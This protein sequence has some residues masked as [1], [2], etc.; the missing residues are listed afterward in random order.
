MSNWSPRHR[1]PGN[2]RSLSE[3]SGGVWLVLDLNPKKRGSQEQQLLALADA[4]A[5]RALPLAYLFSRLPPP[6]LGRELDAR[7]VTVRALDFRRP[8]AAAA[9][10]WPALVEGR[11]RLVHFHFVAPKSPLVMMARAAGA[12]VIVHDHYVLRRASGSRVRELAKR[13]RDGVVGRFVDVRVAVSEFVAASVA[14]V[15]HVPASSLRVVPNGVDVDRFARADGS[16]ARRE[17]GVGG[18]P[19]IA[20]IARL[21][22]EKGV[23]TAIRALARVPPPAQLVLVG[24][25]PLERELRRLAAAL[26]VS[27][28][29]RFVGLRDDVERWL[30]AADVAV[31]PS[32]GE[33]AFGQSVVEAMAAGRPVVVT[34]SGAMPA[35]VGDTGLVVPRDDPPAM[36]RALA[37]LCGDVRRRERL[38]QAAQA[39]ARARF[40]MDAWVARTLAVYAELCPELD[41]AP[42]AARSARAT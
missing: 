19:L 16:A 15:A 3:A 24:D 22:P 18:A 13:L 20:C 38:G 34:R 5:R 35:I 10:L 40:G 29:A 8:L 23:D 11:P 31:T 27:G 17:L 33:E 4:F 32:R 21:S 42:P 41:D 12:R 25:G 6:W 9:A 36:A 1:A 30:A 2:A 28:R 26:G 39:R 37:E 7:G 14:S